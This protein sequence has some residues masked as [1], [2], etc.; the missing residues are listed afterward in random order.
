MKI[1]VLP[2]FNQ[3][4]FSDECYLE[5]DKSI[6]IFG[7]PICKI[8]VEHNP[9]NALNGLQYDL[10]DVRGGGHGGDSRAS[11]YRVLD[12][13]VADAGVRIGILG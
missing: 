11:I 9:T 2:H 3:S 7:H 4:F 1:N 6:Y 8:T 13:G 5:E 10:P 12:A